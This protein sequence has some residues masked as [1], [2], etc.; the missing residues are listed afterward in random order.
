MI[1][2]AGHHRAVA[3]DSDLI[4]QAIAEHPTIS[5][6]GGQI[7]PVKAVAVLQID[8]IPD[9]DALP[10]L[11]PLSGKGIV[12]SRK[13]LFI[14]FIPAAPVPKPVHGQHLPLS[15][16]AE[17]EAALQ[18]LGKGGFEIIGLK[19]MEGNIDLVQP[20]TFQ[21][22]LPLL[23]KQGAVGGQVHAK[24]HCMG[25]FQKPPQQRMAKRLSHQVEIEKI[26]IRPKLGKQRGK[27]LLGHG[28][29]C[30]PGTR[31]EGAAQIADIGNLQIDLVKSFHIHLRKWK[32]Q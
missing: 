29:L 7:R 26:R 22:Q 32:Q 3:Q 5:L 17:G 25:Q 27:L 30:P 31:A 28:T 16:L 13:D 4:P 6:G 15:R 21:K 20:G 24:V 10:L 12:H 11:L 8:P 14:A 23:G 9:P 1:Q 2:T 18:I 19:G